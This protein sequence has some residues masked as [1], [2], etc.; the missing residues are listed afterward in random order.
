VGV[1]RFLKAGAK[2]GHSESVKKVST[3]SLNFE[4]LYKFIGLLHQSISCEH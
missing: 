4:K 1:L 3:H 2:A